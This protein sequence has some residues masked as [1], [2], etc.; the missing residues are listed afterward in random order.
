MSAGKRKPGGFGERQKENKGNCKNKRNRRAVRYEGG[1]L[2]INGG[3]RIKEIGSSLFLPKGVNN[4]ALGADVSEVTTAV[5]LLIA[6]GSST[7]RDRSCSKSLNREV[8]NV[9][10]AVVFIA[11]FVGRATDGGFVAN[12]RGVRSG[13]HSREGNLSLESAYSIKESMLYL[14]LVGRIQSNVSKMSVEAS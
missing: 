13:V 10:R 6:I 12:E 9:R 2:Q 11:G 8:G 7:D 3:G 4:H 1:K 14:R 5:A